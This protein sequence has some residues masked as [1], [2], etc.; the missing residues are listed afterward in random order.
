MIDKTDL[1]RSGSSRKS[2]ASTVKVEIQIAEDESPDIPFTPETK[3]AIEEQHNISK[4]LQGL[5]KQRI[6]P[7]EDIGTVYAYANDKIKTMCV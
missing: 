3:E 2:S 6:C 1:S 5:F 7:S 4:S